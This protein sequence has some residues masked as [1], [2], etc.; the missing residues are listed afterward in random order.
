VRFLLC[1]LLG[2]AAW[3][4]PLPA[5]IDEALRANREI[6][7][8][9]K[10]YEAARQRPSQERSLPDPTLSVGYTSVGRPYPVAGIGR[11]VTANAGVMVS[12]EM[13]FPGKRQLR[14][15]IAEKEASAEF[16]QY[17]AIRLNVIARITEAYHQLHHA[18]VGIRFTK[19]Y[20]E[21][22]QNIMRITEARYAVGRAAQQDIFKAQTQYSIFATQLLRYEQER[23]AKTITINALLNRP[24]NTPVEAPEEVPVGEFTTPLEDLLARIQTA[25]MLER[26]QKM[27]Q[28][29]ELAQDLARKNR[30]PDYTVAGGYFNQGSMP[31]MWQVR[32]DFK[33][34]AYARTKQQAELTER[35]FQASES[36]RNL[37]AAGVSVE[38]QVR[39]AYSLATTA[40][41]LV[42]LYAKSVIPEAQLSLEASMTSYETGAMD[43]LPVFSNFMNVA[44][45]ELMYHEEIMQF[46]VA[47]ARL[48]ELTGGSL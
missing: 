27:V 8:A 34:P 37:E 3:G 14:G 16:E 1:F 25:P 15:A 23:T 26:E 7:A 36:R 42:D 19:R 20:Q 2:I 43:F 18:E 35:A 39:E 21:L 48:E 5:L 6:L 28:R 40:R 13:P 17:R 31:P 33:I 44:E 4:Q 24:Q 47:L 41:K 32:V 46:H 12:Q 22:L 45:Y 29:S 10:R 9:Q 11:E 30:L 38:A